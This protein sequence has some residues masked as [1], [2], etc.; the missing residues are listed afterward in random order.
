MIFGKHTLWNIIIPYGVTFFL[1]KNKKHW[2]F[3]DFQ[4]P[5]IMNFFKWR[6]PLSGTFQEKKMDGLLMK[7]IKSVFFRLFVS[8]F[9][10]IVKFIQCCHGWLFS[11][12]TSDYFNEIIKIQFLSSDLSHK[13]VSILISLEFLRIHI[14]HLNHL[15][16]L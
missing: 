14:G 7:L 8:K 6:M 3:I 9:V 13:K 11:Y 2:G 16:N 10:M 15:L 5:K 4:T 12:K 1:Y